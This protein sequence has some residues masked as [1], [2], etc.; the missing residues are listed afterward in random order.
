VRRTIHSSTADATSAPANAASLGTE[1]IAG[2]IGTV[3][4]V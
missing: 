3:V 4:K 1:I 2:P